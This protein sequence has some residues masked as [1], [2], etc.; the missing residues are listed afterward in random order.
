M[1]I[2]ILENGIKLIIKA[3]G[4]KMLNI[5]LVLLFILF[6][7]LMFFNYKYQKAQVELLE[8]NKKTL[9]LNIKILELNIKKIELLEKRIKEMRWEF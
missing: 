6:F 5:I 8:Q 2:I 7:I 4:Y 3:T 9:E 1:K